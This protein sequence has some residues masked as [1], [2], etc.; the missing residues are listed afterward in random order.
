MLYLSLDEASGNAID[1]HGSN[2]L[3]DNGS[4]GAATGKVNGARDFEANSSQYF[5][6]ATNSTLETGDIDFT[7]AAWINVE[8]FISFPIIVAKDNISVAREYVLYIDTNSGNKPTFEVFN[9]STT[10][11]G[12]AQWATGLSLATWYHIVA[13]HDAINN[14]IGLSVN[15]GTA[16]VNSTTGAAGAN[17][18]PLKIGADLNAGVPSLFFDGLIDEVGFWKRVLTSDERTELYGPGGGGRDYAYIVGSAAE[19]LWARQ[20]I[21][22]P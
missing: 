10:G 19:P 8:S 17:S 9:G 5:D 6:H 3:T 11:I 4:V 12:I 13:W 14:Q 7:L 1:A 15:A 20:M 16:V 22:M 21:A 18:Q 2:D